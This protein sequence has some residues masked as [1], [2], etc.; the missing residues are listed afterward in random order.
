MVRAG[1]LL[2]LEKKL[3]RQFNLHWTLQREKR[4]RKEEV[5]MGGVK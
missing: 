2:L 1:E 5:K 3:P 4:R